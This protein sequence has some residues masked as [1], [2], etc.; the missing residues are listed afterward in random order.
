[1]IFKTIYRPIFLTVIAICATSCIDNTDNG[2]GAYYAVTITDVFPEDAGQNV[3]IRSGKIKYTE[4]NT[5]ETTSMALPQYDPFRLPA[6]LYD[7]EATLNISYIN[8]EGATV[9]K[10]LRALASSVTVTSDTDMELKWF[11]YNPS[12]SLVFSEIYVTGSPNAK[13][14]GGIR[15]S[16]FRIYNNTD[17]TI[18]A[19]GIAIVESVL[20]NAKSSAYEVLTEANNRQVNFTVGAVWTIPGNGTDCPIGPG[21]SIKIVDQAVDWSDQV[22]GALDHTDA[23]FEWWDDN[24]QDTD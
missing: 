17:Q 4:L 9:D 20:I 5:G 13:G 19:D 12:N 16:Y 14:T 15:D 10:S 22:A 18:Y 21:Q 6:G 2:A 3:E 23:D 7:A 8:A 24:A 11:F 1:M